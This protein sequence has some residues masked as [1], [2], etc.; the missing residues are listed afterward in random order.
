MQVEDNQLNEGGR[1]TTLLM[2]V[3]DTQ[4]CEWKRKTKLTWL[5]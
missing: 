5:E 4:L 1:N 3:E 2:Y